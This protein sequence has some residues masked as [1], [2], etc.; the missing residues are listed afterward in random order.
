M[1]RHSR[2]NLFFWSGTLLIAGLLFYGIFSSPTGVKGYLNKKSQLMVLN[3]N[4]G[5][6]ERENDRLY[7]QIKQFKDDPK[8]KM[9]VIRERLGWIH[10]GERKVI[11]VPQR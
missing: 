3:Q 5:V 6:I 2:L 7:R 11:L 8:C 9:K 4:I 1:N 10:E